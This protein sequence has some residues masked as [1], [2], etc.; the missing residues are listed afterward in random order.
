MAD[1]TVR[2]RYEALIGQYE[3]A[4]AKAGISTKSLGSTVESF[5]A[6]SGKSFKGLA[7][8][9]AGIGEGGVAVA[10]GAVLAGAAIFKMGEDGKRSYIELVASVK[11]SK[12]VTG[13]SADE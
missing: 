1:R 9:F 8:D 10:A 3:A 11:A 7:K 5:T 4:M 13:A 2:I 6:K 12:N